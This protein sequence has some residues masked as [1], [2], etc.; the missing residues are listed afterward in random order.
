M[1]ASLI[2]AV[3][4]GC[5]I[6]GGD[7]SRMGGDKANILL[8]GKPL[9][10]HALDRL[11]PQVGRLAVNSAPADWVPADIPTLPDTQADQGPLMGLQIGLLW[12]EMRGF[13]WLFTAPI[14]CPFLPRDV[15]QQLVRGRADG[16]LA[17]VAEAGGRA[18]NLTALW[19][20]D[21]LPT[22]IAQ[23]DQSQRSAHRLISALPLNMVEF[24]EPRAFFNINT[25]GDLKEAE[26]LLSAPG[27]L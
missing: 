19:H 6:A 26:L 27:L 9:Y 20:V 22:V 15:V 3:P 11:R 17:I 23:L 21:V 2:D 18:H 4:A 1:P 10:Q 24:E 7:G 25:P 8:G 5:L 16:S 12:A 14:D 13:K